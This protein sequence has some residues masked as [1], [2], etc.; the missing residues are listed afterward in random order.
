MIK[1]DQIV[2][3]KWNGQTKQYWIS[4]G[5]NCTK[6]G[7]EFEAKAEDLPSKSSIFVDVICDYCGQVFPMRMYAYNN[8]AKSGKIACKHCKGKKAK[9]TNLDKYGVENVM[10]VDEIHDKMKSTMLLTYGVEHPS[11]SKDLHAKAMSKYNF[12]DALN[13]RKET[14][15][16]KYGVDN[17][18]KSQD[19]IDKAKNTCRKKYGGDSSQCDEQVRAKSIQSMLNG[20][21]IQSSKAERAMT[22]LLIDMYGKENCHPQFPLDKIVM[23]CL[24]DYN[25]I[26]IDVE[27]DG[28]FWHKDK[29]ES[30]KRRDYYCIRR[31]YKVLRFFSKYNVPTKEQIKQGVDYLVNSEHKHLRI[32]I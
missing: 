2:K 21:A 7:D 10:Q 29:Q 6:M 11:Q 28:E 31:G 5:Y 24:L 12:S 15:L 13:K 23:D 16:L 14:C 27:Y 22:D 8:S 26:K 30:D 3:V 9:E 17:A 19:V 25:G 18:S 20:G 4:K 1:P 32:D